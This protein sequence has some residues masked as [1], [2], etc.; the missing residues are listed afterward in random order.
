MSNTL[1]IT[2]VIPKDGAR[3]DVTSGGATAIQQQ[4]Q[5]VLSRP[6]AAGELLTTFSDGTNMVPLIGTEHPMRPGYYAAKYAI[7]QPRGVAKSTLDLTLTYEPLGPTKDVIL[8]PE[9]EPQTVDS[10]VVEWG[11]S[12]GTS[13]R[14]LLRGVDTNA[15]PVVNSAGD[16]F[17]SVPTVETPAPEFVK[18]V[19]FK[20][21]Q[22]YWP[23]MC[24]INA[25]A[26]TIGAVDCP[27]NSLLCTVCEK[28]NIG[29]E[30]WPYQYTIRMRYR[31]NLIK[32]T[33][34]SAEEE[35]GWNVAVVD[36]GMREL[37]SSGKP[38]LI[39]I[40][41]EETG[42]ESTV[43][44]PE[45]LDGTGHKVDRSGSTGGSGQPVLLVFQAY[46]TATFPDWFT[47]EPGNNV[48]PPPNNGG[49]E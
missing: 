43:T 15:T 27:A 47:S 35:I 32:K 49:N 12:D 10:L 9:E 7:S 3:Y 13:S 26:M 16:P 46:K 41:S 5:I 17:E 29:D 34:A 25:A 4:Y 36:A 6:L 28:L 19:K 39:T 44:S 21:R 8:D 33:Y 2:R 37:D 45:L 24:H 20:T 30:I 31:S 18:V 23:Y 40:Q 42:R 38:K 22:V 14:E 1:S 48:P 11:W